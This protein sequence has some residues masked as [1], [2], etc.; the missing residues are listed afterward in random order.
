MAASERGARRAPP[1][2]LN[3]VDLLRALRNNGAVGSAVGGVGSA[4]AKPSGMPRALTWE[5][6]EQAWD[7]PLE[8]WGVPWAL[9]REA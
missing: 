4:V 7:L 2:L 5:A 3:G 6:W 8:A 1:G 9:P